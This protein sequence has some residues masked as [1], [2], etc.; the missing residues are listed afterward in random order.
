M[1]AEKITKALA[2]Y[3][4]PIAVLIIG[5]LLILLPTK[6]TLSKDDADF[7]GEEQRLSAILEEIR[8]VGKTDVLLS[9]EG[10]VIVCEG[11]DDAGIRLIIVNSVSA[12]TGLSWDDIQVQKLKQI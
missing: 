2:K 12:Y 1:K 11:A 3:K 9:E 7:H 6:S 10:A 4:Y 8:G 5:L